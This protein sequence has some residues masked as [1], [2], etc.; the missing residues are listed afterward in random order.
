MKNMHIPTSTVTI[1]R[2]TDHSECMLFNNLS[3]HIEASVG[4]SEVREKP[5]LKVDLR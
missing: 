4:R 5:C 1:A 2:Y 3:T